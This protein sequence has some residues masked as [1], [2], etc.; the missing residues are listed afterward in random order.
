MV[1]G[2]LL[3]DGP[4]GFLR[5]RHHLEDLHQTRTHRTPGIRDSWIRDGASKDG[6]PPAAGLAGGGTGLAATRP[7]LPE[8]LSGVVLVEVFLVIVAGIGVT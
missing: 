6:G 2:C 8:A 3:R 7:A 5:L 4:D 1:A